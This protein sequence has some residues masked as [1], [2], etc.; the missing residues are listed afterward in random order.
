VRRE[1][2][3]LLVEL[4][5]LGACRQLIKP[6][7]QREDLVSLQPGDL[8]TYIEGDSWI[9]IGRE[10]QPLKAP[11]VGIVISTFDE[12]GIKVLWATGELTMEWRSQIQLY[13]EYLAIR[14]KE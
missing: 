3:D 13:K 11:P 6:A 9:F 2:E 1:F 12:L 8:I 14:E 5:R 10:G 7:N 4:G